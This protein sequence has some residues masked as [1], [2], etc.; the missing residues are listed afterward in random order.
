MDLMK[1]DACPLCGCKDG[2]KVETT[3]VF[4]DTT[5]K[6][7]FYECPGC[8]V[9][10]QWPRLTQEEEGRFYRD[11]FEKFMESRN[12]QG[13]LDWT[14]PERHIKS[15]SDQRE[16]REKYLRPFYEGLANKKDP[17]LLEVGC[18]SGF[19]MNGLAERYG[20]TA[21]GIEPSGAFSSFL[22]NEGYVVFPN[23]EDH[24]RHCP[25]HQYDI[26]TNYFVLEHIQDPVFFCRALFEKLRPGGHLIME[27]PNAADPLR[28]L[29]PTDAFKQF[30]WSVAHP[31]YFTS[32]SLEYLLGTALPD[33]PIKVFGDQRYDIGNHVRWLRE[34]RPGGQKTLSSV[35][36]AEFDESFRRSLIQSGN[37]DTLVAIV[38]KPG[39]TQ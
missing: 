34:G 1:P 3:F 38:E 14:G 9:F 23:M 24:D 6:R 36:G 12:S 33:A 30:Y 29:Y 27:I 39:R 17:R 26:I 5:G 20:I 21:V 4:G 19:M 35:F 2:I 15:N 11:E 32:K 13:G 16:R 22:K 18:S 8:S 25:Q 31:W 28:T 10:F 37:C 7:S